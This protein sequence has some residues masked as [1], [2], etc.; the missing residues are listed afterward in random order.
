MK[1]I[2]VLFNPSADKGRAL[3]KKNIITSLLTKNNV[4]HNLLITKSEEHLREQVKIL[5]KNSD[6][7]V[8]AGGDSTFNIAANEIIKNDLNLT[9]GM[10][11]TGSSNDIV[12]QFNLNNTEDA[13]FAV[14]KLNTKKID[15]GFVKNKGKI[16]TF[17]IGQVNI[18]LGAH[19]NKY[20]EEKLKTGSIF[21]KNQT[22]SGILGI[23][24]TYKKKHI[25]FNIKI[26]SKSSEFK[27]NIILVVFSN[28]K[29]WATGKI[30]TP[31]SR[32]DDGLLEAFIIEDSPIYYLFYVGLLTSKSNHQNKKKI[33][34]LSSSNYRVQSKTKFA[35][36]ADG[37]IIGG[38]EN[39]E[40]FSDLNIGTYKRALN[41]IVP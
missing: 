1:K 33:R 5:S 26:K 25:P 15:I 37:E 17:F 2:P 40:N 41:I 29:Y 16:I 10:I 34:I 18:G 7:I 20:V 28:I 32:P 13:C 35:V 8:T 21:S 6:I 30:I 3:T 11:G 14:K 38:Y 27:K 24:N 31:Q 39:P 19:V 23:F 12:K 9:L 36:Q 22:I 4:N